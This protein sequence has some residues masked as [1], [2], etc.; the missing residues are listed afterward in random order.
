MNAEP[1]DVALDPTVLGDLQ[2]RLRNTRWP[3]VIG[4]DSWDY[5]VP[6]AWLRDMATY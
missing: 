1:F 2:A 5:G 4:E 3:D 6:Q